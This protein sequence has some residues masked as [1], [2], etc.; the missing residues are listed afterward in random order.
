[1]REKRNEFSS[2]EYDSIGLVKKNMGID[3]LVK[4]AD[5]LN[6]HSGL[7]AMIYGYLFKITEKFLEIDKR[8]TELEK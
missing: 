1:M 3:E 4:K 6:V 7:L 5:E 2:K 8:L